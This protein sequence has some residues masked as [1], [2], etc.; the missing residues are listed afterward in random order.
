MPCERA[1]S[2][3]QSRAMSASTA[4]YKMPISA[5]TIPT[6]RKRGYIGPRSSADAL[7]WPSLGFDA[8][9]IRFS[10]SEHFSFHQPWGTSACI[11][12]YGVKESQLLSFCAKN[13]PPMHRSRLLKPAKS[14]GTKTALDATRYGW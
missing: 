8:I 10:A 12:H 2:F 4:P 5:V 11:L 6:L 3:H 13:F 14:L 9:S 1:G 7:S